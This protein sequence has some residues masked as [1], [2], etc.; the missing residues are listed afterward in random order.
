MITPAWLQAAGLL[1]WGF[2]AGQAV[3]GA[4]LGGVRLLLSISGMRLNLVDRDLIRAVDLTALAVL[5]L[6]V[7]FVTASGLPNGLLAAAGWLPVALFPL[8]LIDGQSETRFRLR[9]LALSLRNSRNPE[10]DRITDLA[11]PYLAT[12]LLAAGVIAKPSN[13]FFW[14]TAAVVVSWLF[15]ACRASRPGGIVIFACAAL[16]AIAGGHGLST[17]L[18]RTQGTL[19]DWVV[20][21]ISDSDPNPSG[22][23]TRI[24]DLGRIKLS[25][26]IVWRVEQA[27]PAQVP[28]L[29]RTGVFSRYAHG[30]W[31]A[32]QLAFAPAAILPAEEA[33]WLRLHGQSHKGTALLPLPIDAGRIAGAVGNP[34]RSA[35][36]L[37]RL[38]QAPPVLDA[39]VGRASTAA[40]PNPDAADLQL[41]AGVADIL[42]RLP[43]IA[44]LAGRSE[45]ERLAG[46][47][48]WFA[49]NFRYT[50]FLGDKEHGSRDLE[51]FL[52]ADRAGHCEYF[53]TSTVLLLRAL[54]IPARYVTGYSVQEYSRLERAFVVR[55]KHAHAW[56]E[57]LIDGKWVE[58]DTTPSEWLSVEEDAAPWWRPLA[59][60][61]SFAW[62]RLVELRRDIAASDN[63]WGGIAL[64][65]LLV[66]LLVW[67]AMKQT[68]KR[69]ESGC[70]GA[71]AGAQAEDASGSEM[72]AFRR[73]EQELSVLGL[74]RGPG[75]PP[76]AWIAR[77]AR[78]GRSVVDEVRI[79]GARNL[80]E[81]TYRCRYGGK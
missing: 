7:G 16:A 6:V 69:A 9:H 45:R 52:L 4:I 12:A 1:L 68:R 42:R 26:R 59:D 65:G 5:L 11:A 24:G 35:S 46:L 70:G 62:R 37:V 34:R 55:Q 3:L 19:Q 29:L 25:E 40:A 44:A 73:L 74:G 76:R 50:L 15:L 79:I 77:V 64:G 67:L 17:L 28:L 71:K 27:L 63:P 41:P 32:G 30:A 36:G 23:Q 81:A 10:A 14:G 20:E 8:L 72:R 58:V 21:A 80:V 33:P 47:E 53:A 54:G 75:E 2:A 56:A 78:D 18:Q 66:L 22:S 31:T 48:S 51:R 49:A 57:A 39:R 43:E 60:A 38:D 61:A 13:W